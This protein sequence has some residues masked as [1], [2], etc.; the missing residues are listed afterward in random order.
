M[1]TQRAISSPGRGHLLRVVPGS[2]LHTVP[3]LL[4]KLVEFY[5]RYST[6]RASSTPSQDVWARDMHEDA[7][8]I[9]E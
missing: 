8:T 2:F 6:G 9:H 1:G 3:L 4:Y 5:Y 7:S